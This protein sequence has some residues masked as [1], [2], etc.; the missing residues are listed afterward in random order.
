M[1]DIKNKKHLKQILSMYKTFSSIRAVEGSKWKLSY[2][3]GNK[4]KL[5]KGSE[6]LMTVKGG[7]LENPRIVTDNDVSGYYCFECIC[8]SRES[9][10][11]AADFLDN[12]LDEAEIEDTY[13]YP[14]QGEDY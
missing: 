5:E 4:A 1:I 13:D 3:F 6:R 11:E 10:V 14:I 9:A 8:E 12:Q 7:N 2:V